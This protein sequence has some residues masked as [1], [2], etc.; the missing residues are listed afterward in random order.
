MGTVDKKRFL[1]RCALCFSTKERT[2]IVRP[3]F[4]SWGKIS[5]SLETVSTTGQ[6]QHPT[7]INPED[8]GS[9]FLRY[10]TIS[11]PEKP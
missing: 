5:P 1:F 3:S 11:Q 8:G 2:G 7:H 6:I 10:Y 4:I 9:M